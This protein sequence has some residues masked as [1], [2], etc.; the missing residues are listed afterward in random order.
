MRWRRWLSRRRTAGNRQNERGA[1]LR[2]VKEKKGRRR[3]GG[4]RPRE[5]H[6]LGKQDGV[7]IEG[8]LASGQNEQM[9][10]V[11]QVQLF[12]PG[13]RRNRLVPGYPPCHP[14]AS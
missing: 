1:E 6:G 11:Q 2:S 14:L 9:R 4:L 8:A 5:P 13:H 3:S 12:N 7:Q 10:V